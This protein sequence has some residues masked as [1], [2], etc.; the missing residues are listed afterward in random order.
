[1]DVNINYILLVYGLIFFMLCMIA[2]MLPKYNTTWYFAP[3]LSLLSSFS[4]LYAMADFIEMQSLNNPDS[5][6]LIWFACLVSL[7]SYL[8]LLEIARRTGNNLFCSVQPSSPWVFGTVSLVSAV[9]LALIS[10]ASIVGLVK[11]ARPFVSIL[12]AL[13]T[14]IVLFATK[15]RKGGRY[16]TSHNAIWILIL[17]LVFISYSLSSI[18]LLLT[19]PPLPIWL[20]LQEYFPHLFGFSV[21]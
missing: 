19:N 5:T 18:F 13:L 3:H 9:L 10:W 17:A 20:P 15:R 11:T 8:L 21:Q 16:I 2:F 6:W 1:M 12:A 14:G 7:T 4:I